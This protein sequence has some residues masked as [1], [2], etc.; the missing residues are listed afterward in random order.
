MT[1]FNGRKVKNK[2]S[3]VRSISSPGCLSFLAPDGH[4]KHFAKTRVGVHSVF[5]HVSIWKQVMLSGS[6]AMLL[7][8]IPLPDS[9]IW[10][11]K[12]TGLKA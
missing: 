3:Y 7:P 5:A 2:V 10:E 4:T 9:K 8:Y 6:A 12:K 1:L 11:A